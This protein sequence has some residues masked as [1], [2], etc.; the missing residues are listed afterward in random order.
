MMS[1]RTL[2]QIRD[3]MM[4]RLDKKYTLI[5]VSY[6]DELTDKQVD[7]IAH[8]DFETLWDD[9]SDYE[10]E[11]RWQGT[12]Y[13]LN[14][15]LDDVI[16]DWER[17]DETNYS[18]LKDDFRMSDPWYEVKEAIEDRDESDFIRDLARNTSD[19]LMRVSVTD[20]DSAFP[21]GAEGPTEEDALAAVGLPVTEK[22]IKVMGS[23]LAEVN[24]EYSGAVASWVFAADVEWLYRLPSDPET[25][26]E[27]TDPFLWLGNPWQGDGWVNEQPFEGTV[28]FKRG[29]LRTDR[30]AWGYGWDQVVGGA[31]LPA[32]EP[33]GL[34]VVE[35]KEE[36]V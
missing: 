12:E 26:I 22:N 15:L 5:Y 19:V 30:D 33:S 20:E 23:I 25:I 13:V 4:N 9:I 18:D 11:A 3:E 24:F 7:A 29:V 31:Y 16:H 14:E 35:L 36:E 6:N 17:E 1:E 21:V 8:G 32:L 10:S 34:R 2:D 28:R 27:I